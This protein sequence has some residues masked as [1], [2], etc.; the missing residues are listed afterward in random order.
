[1][2]ASPLSTE[3][4][5]SR[6]ASGGA[7][8]RVEAVQAPVIPIVAGWIRET[9]GTIS[10]GQGV[11]SY[12]PPREAI[13]S[14][15]TFGGELADHRYGPVEG[16]PRLVAR[17]EAQAAR[18]ERPRRR[19][20]QPRGRDR[21]RQHGVPERG[22][23]H[24]RSGRRDHPA[25]AVLLQ[26]RHG[27]RAGRL[28]HRAGRDAARLPARSRGARRAP[29]R[30]G[31]ARSSRCRRTTRPARS[32]RRRPCARSTHLCR[33]RGLFH[34]H[35]EAYEYFTYDEPHVSPGAFAGAAGHTISMWS[36]SKAFGFASWRIG[37]MTIPEALF[38]AVN[39]IQDTNLICPAGGVAARRAR[40]ARR[41]AALLRRPRAGAGP[42]ALAGLRAAR[43]ARRSRRGAG[44]ARRV[45]RAAAGEDRARS[46]TSSPNA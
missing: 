36:L 10:L 46:R 22:A 41:R 24:R 21:R 27:D 26:P 28:P 4:R 29:S 9:P 3:P 6:A 18:R 38:D 39:K 2:S 7:S 30:R 37:Y 15:A 23:G 11:V 25:G 20:R 8:A 14:L 44:R 43:H 19:A 34:I 16:L 13:A 31:R 5:T 42:G 40:R 17:L 35:D 45:L 33:E 32:I 1:M 12:G